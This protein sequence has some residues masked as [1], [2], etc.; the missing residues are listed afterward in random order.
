MVT[1]NNVRNCTERPRATS[2][3]VGIDDS[4]VAPGVIFQALMKE[5]SGVSSQFT[6]VPPRASWQQGGSFLGK[7]ILV[8][9]ENRKQGEY[10]VVVGL[11]YEV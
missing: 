9:K 1:V 7:G 8:G 3:S 2:Y 11:T 6:H 4:W 10:K 5:R